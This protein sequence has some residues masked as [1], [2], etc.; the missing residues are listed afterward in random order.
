L[1]Y[2][3]EQ[4]QTRFRDFKSAENHIRIFE[5]P[6]AVE[7]ETL[8]TDLQ[9]EVIKLTSNNNFKDYFKENGLQKFYTALPEDSFPNVK[10]HAREIMSIF[11]STY[12]Y[13]HKFSKMKYVKSKYRTNLSD[14]HLQATLLIGTTKL[15][16]NYKEI[17]K[18][19]QFQISH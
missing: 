17:L 10:N 14:E 3:K 9:L 4:F 5:N 11:S 2:L 13:E 19:K 8:P 1:T 6:F 18:S 15:D 12:F 16:A 7:I